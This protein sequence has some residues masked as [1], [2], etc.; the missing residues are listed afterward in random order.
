M[1]RVYGKTRPLKTVT[2]MALTLSLALSGCASSGSS[3]DRTD[4]THRQT[5]SVPTDISA[6]EL[7]DKALAEGTIIVYTVSTRTVDVK[8]S[9]EKEYP[10]LTVEV[11]DLRSPNLVD[12]VEAD[13]KS[14]THGCDVVMCN[15]NSGEFKSRL[16]DTGIVVPYIPDDI[17]GKMKQGMV[18]DVVSFLNEA[19]ILFYNAD[20]FTSAPIKNIWELTDDKYKGR[21]YMPNP[22]QS[23]STYAFAGATFD[24]DEKLLN[25]YKSYMGTE[26]DIPEGSSISEEFW[27]KVAANAVFTNS[28][29][30]VLEALNNS[31]ADMGFSVSSKLRFQ[32][33]GYSIE[34][35]YNLTPFSG[36]RT[37]FAVMMASGSEH[38][39]G[40]ALFIR[41]LLGESDG[42]GEGYKPFSTKGTW[43]ARTD[44]ADG[45]DVNV[46]DIDLI[47][48]DQDQLIARKEKMTK[49]W[50]KL[51]KENSGYTMEK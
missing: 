27:T 26:P 47:T 36:C 33:V 34:P 37:S 38:Q 25:A 31:E 45:T 39:Y 12:E 32:E 46:E 3:A 13:A 11:R 35:L 10:G 50:N 2:A 15:D 18:G 5:L 43:S 9:F 16:V 7:Y 49:L 30:E 21:I 41:Y 51:L 23:F 1:D 44:V 20:K 4:D 48:P 6:K 24:H 8:E 14:H 42:Q 40:A 19:E 17:K 28:S 22:L 29:D